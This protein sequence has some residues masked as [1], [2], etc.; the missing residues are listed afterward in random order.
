MSEHVISKGLDLPITGKPVQEIS[1]AAP[2]KQVAILGHDYPTM[3]PRM[4]VE[5]GN[6]VKKGQILFEDRK[7]EGIRFTAPAAGTI[8]AIHRGERRAF[9]SLVID[10]AASEEQVSFASHTGQAPSELTG[11]QVRTLL[12]E[13]GLWTA[14]RQRPYSRVP[15]IDQSCDDLFIT[16]VDTRPLA[17]SIAAIVAGQDA[18][19]KAGLA[20]VTKLT[21]GPTYLCVGQDWS[22]DCSDIPGVNT[23]VFHGM[24]PAGLVG[25]HIH[26][27]APVGRKHTA[28][29]LG[30]QDLIA[31]GK[32]FTTGKLDT[33]RVVAL[34]GP[35]ATNPRLVRTRLGAS[36]VELTEGELADGE[37]RTISGSVLYGHTAT[38]DVLG[39]LN[40][41]D[42]QVSCLAEDRAR[43]MLGWLG[44]GT[45][46]FST[47]K[48]FLSRWLPAK[49]LDF[50]TT[51]HGSHRAMVPIGM[52]E[53][54]MPLDIMPTFL[55]RSILVSDLERAEQLGC[56]EL[57][58]EDL[59]LCSF[60]SPGKEDYGKA[61]RNVLTQIH[62]EG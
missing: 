46:K 6:Q 28:W 36:I 57:D 2:A 35:V 13:S 34:A 54:V 37:T 4:A 29:H 20:A 19:V 61:L 17:P 47:V 42:Q 38:S 39:Y 62:A 49:D 40:R 14:L 10:V 41:Y 58:E 18:A 11:A 50:T 23:E 31:I 27:L 21:D 26:T 24:H 30:I 32:L 59:A 52:F 15:S 56:L 1:D 51:T 5:V 8:S 33:S 7:G 44:L 43:V 55:L 60:V 3:K 48:A 9:I 16:A 45:N 25:T 22:L 12:S 53:A